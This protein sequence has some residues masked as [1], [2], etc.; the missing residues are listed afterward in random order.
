MKTMNEPI[1]ILNSG[2]TPIRVKD[3]KTAIKL[4]FREK[5]SIVDPTDYAV[6]EWDEWCLLPVNEGDKYI[7]TTSDPVKLPE[8]VILTHYDKVSRYDLKLSK[9]N[10]F[11]RDKYTCQYTG[12]TLTKKEAD[13]DHIVPKSKGGKTVWTNLV[14]CDKKINRAKGP[15]HLKDTKFKLI[16]KPKK[17]DSVSIMID[18]NRKY[19]ESWKKFVKI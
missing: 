1:L 12:K 2:W 19:P 15:K 4:V 7:S 14:V 16:K 10:I 13:I 11:I 5:A 18:V 17:P 8:V 3:V 9:K 6:Y